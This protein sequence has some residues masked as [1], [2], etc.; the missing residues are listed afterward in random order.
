MKFGLYV[1]PQFQDDTELAAATD[2]MAEQV[3]TAR[4]AGYASIFVPHHYLSAPMRMF[5]ANIL[6]ARLAAEAGNMRIG[7][8][9]WLMGMTNPVQIAEEAATLDWVAPG[10]YTLALGL[11]YREEE[12][13]AFG[14]TART[15]AVRTT[16]AVDV[17]RK[18]WGQERVTHE[19]RFF[20]LTDVGAS[21]R[22]RNGKSLP[23]WI[24]ANLDPAVK[25]AA[26][27]GDAWLASFAH[28]WE[29]LGGSFAL[30]NAER[31]AAGLP[32]PVERPLCRECFI[33][34]TQAKALE[35]ARDPLIYKYGAYH[36]WGSQ[37]VTDQSFANDFGAYQADRFIIGDKAMAKDRVLWFKETL[38]V[39]HLILRMQWPGLPQADVLRSIEFMG[40]VLQDISE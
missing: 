15:R 37:N 33:A 22:P 16:E 9:I 20:K 10:G 6:L 13:Q 19:G 21:I 14:E 2:N 25:R 39:D 23:L 27:I 5:Q 26:R 35:L 40:E 29:A 17:I 38:G 30:Y 1:N 32:P 4:D 7:P 36:S 28:S 3:R 8:G 18:L 11:G 24:G 12:F 31:D 34:P